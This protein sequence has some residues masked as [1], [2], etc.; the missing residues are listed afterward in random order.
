MGSLRL[1]PKLVTVIAACA[2][3]TMDLRNTDEAMLLESERR[4]AI[5][6]AQLGRDEGL[7]IRTRRLARL[8]PQTFN[9]GMAALV[10]QVATRPGHSCRPLTSGAGHD[11]QRMARLSPLR[12]S[13]CLQSGAS[14]TTRRAHRA[15]ASAAGADVL[16]HPV[17]PRRLKPAC[18]RSSRYRWSRLGPRQSSCGVPLCCAPQALARAGRR[19]EPRP[20]TVPASGLAQERRRVT[21]VSGS[22]PPMTLLEANDAK[23]AEL[24]ESVMGEA[25]SHDPPGAVTGCRSRG[26]WA[27]PHQVVRGATPG[28]WH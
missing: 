14:A 3:L 11:A 28:F 19:L 26:S 6:L 9:A 4:L 8:E 7:A 16:L 2:R 1:H 21:A 5:S 20:G 18:S 10:S 23:A 22:E 24:D 12:C 27:S 15:R 25:A 17:E 13:W